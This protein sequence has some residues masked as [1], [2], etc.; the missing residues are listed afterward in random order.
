MLV[1][2]AHA[3]MTADQILDAQKRGHVTDLTGDVLV[4]LAA[5]LG[6]EVPGPDELGERATRAS[7]SPAGGFGFRKLCGPAAAQR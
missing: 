2:M 7:G 4:A 5:E 3:G 1:D 6:I